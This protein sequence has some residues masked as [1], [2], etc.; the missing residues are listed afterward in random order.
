M[1]HSDERYLMVRSFKGRTADAVAGYDLRSKGD[2]P[3]LERVADDLKKSTPLCV[4]A[5]P[6]FVRDAS[7]IAKRP[8]EPIEAENCF[9]RGVGRRL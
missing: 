2:A 4:A 6:G 8:T 9:G 3:L 5:V 7:P 1:A